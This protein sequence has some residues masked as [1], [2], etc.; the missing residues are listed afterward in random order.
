MC[1]RG[2]GQCQPGHIAATGR[3]ARGWGWGMQPPQALQGGTRAWGGEPHRGL[4]HVQGGRSICA[5]LAPASSRAGVSWEASHHEMSYRDHE[6]LQIHSVTKST[7]QSSLNVYS[8]SYMLFTQTLTNPCPKTLITTDFVDFVVML[9]CS[10]KLLASCGEY[11]IYTA[12]HITNL[13][14]SSQ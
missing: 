11:A 3:G 9:A 6:L 5:A 13:H 4:Q 10:V 14:V 7:P 1:R 8:S 12:F 2:W